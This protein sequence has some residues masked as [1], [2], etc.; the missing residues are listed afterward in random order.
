MTA[1]DAA[2]EFFATDPSPRASWRMAVLMGR[3]SRT[4]KFALGHALLQLAGQGHAEVSLADLAAPYALSLAER[5]ADAPQAP[6]GSAGGTTDFLT[7]V[8][9]EGPQSLRLGHPTEELLAAA[10]R[11]MPVMVMQKFH[12]LSGAALGHR[13][14]ELGPGTGGRRTVRFTD[15][16]RRIAASEQA[17]GL[18]TELGA[19]WRIVENSFDT[20]IG[21]SLIDDGLRV[22]GPTMGLTD[23]KRRRPIAHLTPA[24]IGFQ[25]HR[26]L[27]CD[28]V[29]VPGAPVQVDH[30]FP[31]ALMTRYSAVRAWPG[32][33]LDL[34]WNLA[35]AHKACNGG[36]SDRP[37]E[38]VEL[39]R[40]AR[41]NIAIM[42]SPHPLRRTLELQLRI[43]HG[44]RRAANWPEFLRE[45]RALV[46]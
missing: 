41:R 19:R 26:C 27:I 16:L 40:L 42:S 11:S 36:K 35:P 1:A 39:L 23:R 13:F 14:Y 4:Y 3:N 15:A 32:P 9:R 18:H 44:N 31:R 29:I 7:V 24:V 21:R 28:D 17:P 46:A 37:P 34:L 30:V 45:V 38:D 43:P 33:D 2:Q 8:G 25:H 5:A 6:G 20:G 12:N 10:V 22:D